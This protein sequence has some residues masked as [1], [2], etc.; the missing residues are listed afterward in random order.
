M[1][2]ALYNYGLETGWKDWIVE[3]SK[4]RLAFYPLYCNELN[5]NTLI[6]SKNMR[7]ISSLGYAGLFRASGDVRS[8]Y[9]SYSSTTAG[10]ETA[11]GSRR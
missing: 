8:A 5:V 9:G 3:E 1:Q 7:G 10:E 4:R 6:E 2:S 11:L